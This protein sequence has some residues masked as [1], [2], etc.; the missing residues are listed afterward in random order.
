MFWMVCILFVFLILL[1]VRNF[2]KVG[3]SFVFYLGLV[4]RVLLVKGLFFWCC[5]IWCEFKL[6]L[7]VEIL[8]VVVRLVV[9][10]S[11]VCMVKIREEDKWF[12]DEE[13]GYYKGWLFIVREFMIFYNDY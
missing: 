6:N 8:L 9:R 2:L 12:E 1:F 11:F 5:V 13:K 3:L 10:R 7:V 4:V